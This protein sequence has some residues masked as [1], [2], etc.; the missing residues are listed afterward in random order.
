M[1]AQGVTTMGKKIVVFLVVAFLAATWFVQS[2]SAQQPVTGPVAGSYGERF[3]DYKSGYGG[4]LHCWRGRSDGFLHFGDF[5]IRKEA[6]AL[7]QQCIDAGVLAAG[8]NWSGYQATP[9]HQPN[10]WETTFLGFP[11]WLWLTLLA[12]ILALLALLCCLDHRRPLRERW[13]A[14]APRPKEKAEKPEPAGKLPESGVIATPAGR[15]VPDVRGA[16][17]PATTV[18]EEPAELDLGAP[19]PAVA[20]RPGRYVRNEDILYLGDEEVGRASAMLSVIDA[21]FVHIEKL[22]ANLDMD[23]TKWAK[24]TEAKVG[25]KVASLAIITADGTVAL[26]DLRLKA[27]MSGYIREVKRAWLR[28]PDGK[29]GYTDHPFKM[30]LPVRMDAT[31]E[32]LS[33]RLKKQ[34]F[35][36]RAIVVVEFIVG[37]PPKRGAKAAPETK[38]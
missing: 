19:M 34:S 15:P 33:P 20:S 27:V 10:W 18:A 16:E 1:A 14:L 2:A 24:T 35:K 8:P 28:L 26:N 22:F 23:E 3:A 36:G 30:T 7:I 25:Q 31:L 6:D 17:P 29:G 13:R 9:T 5:M 32:S 38:K 12:L 21:P 11:L 4:I 37:K